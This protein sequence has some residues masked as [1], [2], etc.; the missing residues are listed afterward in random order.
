MHAQTITVY[1]YGS[2]R[3]MLPETA[4]LDGV[5]PKRAEDYWLA[6][7]L[8]LSL[9]QIYSSIDHLPLLLSLSLFTHIATVD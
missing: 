9:C 1:G 7:Q 3:V 6:R 8:S 2:S 5:V 4:T